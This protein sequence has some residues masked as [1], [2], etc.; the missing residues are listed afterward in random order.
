MMAKYWS[1]LFYTRVWTYVLNKHIRYTHMITSLL[2]IIMRTEVLLCIWTFEKKSVVF[3][4]FIY[5]KQLIKQRRR[6]KTNS[7]DT[8]MV[9]S[10]HRFNRHDQHSNHHHHHHQNWTVSLLMTSNNMSGNKSICSAFLSLKKWVWTLVNLS[11]KGNRIDR[12]TFKQFEQ[13]TNFW[14]NIANG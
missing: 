5:R 7:N 1:N 2:S 12:Q 4:L 11:S 8:M 14:I 6:N 3:L 9:T 13:L 10:T